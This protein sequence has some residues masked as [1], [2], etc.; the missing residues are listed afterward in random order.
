MIF[1]SLGFGNIVVVI[2]LHQEQDLQYE[3]PD[4]ITITYCY[5]EKHI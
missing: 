4:K 5:W 2:Q 1:N 3:G